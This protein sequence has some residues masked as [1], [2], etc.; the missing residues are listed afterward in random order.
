MKL[1]LW[2]VVIVTHP[3]LPATYCWAEYQDTT[4]TEGTYEHDI[5]TEQQ[6]KLNQGINN[7]WWWVSYYLW[8]IQTINSKSMDIQKEFGYYSNNKE[9]IVNN[10]TWYKFAE[11]PLF[12]LIST[13]LLWFLVITVCMG[14]ETNNFVEV[15]LKVTNRNGQPSAQLGAGHNYQD[16]WSQCI[17]MDSNRI[18]ADWK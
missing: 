9:I 10:K 15:K 2:T 17:K 11:T 1:F 8:N 7:F 4:R 16:R 18:D 5:V 13:E 14:F 6:I 12:F 3:P